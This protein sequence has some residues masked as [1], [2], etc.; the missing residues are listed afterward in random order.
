MDALN[1][2]NK[3]TA[4]HGRVPLVP[5]RSATIHPKTI[6][7]YRLGRPRCVSAGAVFGCLFSPV[8]YR[9][10][11][12]VFRLVLAAHFLNGWAKKKSES[13]NCPL[14]PLFSCPSPKNSTNKSRG[15]QKNE[16]GRVVAHVPY[17]IP[18]R[19]PPPQPPF[20]PPPRRLRRFRP[21]VPEPPAPLGPPP[22][23]AAAAGPTRRS[24]RPGSAGAPNNRGGEERGGEGEMK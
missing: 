24:R 3:S 8:G 18:P 16:A 10:T 5:E 4:N 14:F 11:Q 12:G 1:A 23:T 20:P 19:P 13:L 7:R 15:T 17:R 22:G 6:S 21:P 2:A 9:E